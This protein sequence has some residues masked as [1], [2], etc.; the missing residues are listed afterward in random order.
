[1]E[2]QG[3]RGPAATPPPAYRSLA[4]LCVPYR[5]VCSDN[6]FFIWVRP[7]LGVDGQKSKGESECKMRYTMHYGVGG[8]GYNF[9]GDY[10]QKGVG[11]VIPRYCITRLRVRFQKGSK[12]GT[13]PTVACAGVMPPE[14]MLAE[15][16]GSSP[17]AQ[18]R[19]VEG[20]G[21]SRR[22][23][24][25][26]PAIGVRRRVSKKKKEKVGCTDRGGGTQ[27]RWG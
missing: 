10:K 21:G 9:S 27:A 16:Q 18:R 26:T 1:M 20:E 2:R 23:Q 25:S 13:P 8:T 6:P 7:F 14:G 15:Q 4:R 22:C 19:V 3:R 11:T 12:K 17:P 24:Y 5:I